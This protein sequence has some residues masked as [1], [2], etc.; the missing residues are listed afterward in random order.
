VDRIAAA[1]GPTRAMPANMSVTAAT[2]QT[3]AMP[4]SQ[5]QPASVTV[6]GRSSPIRAEPIVRVTAAPVQTSVEKARG[7]TRW[8]M[9]SVTR[10]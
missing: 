2:V 9:L 5:P 6:P 7:G 10:M 8:A 4:A 3:S 1:D